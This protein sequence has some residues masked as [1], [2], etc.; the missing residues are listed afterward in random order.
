[1]ERMKVTYRL[2]LGTEQSEGKVKRS[3]V[4]TLGPLVIFAKDHLCKGIH[5]SE[6]HELVD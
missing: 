1:M 3:M 2:S 5:E 4:H 6:S